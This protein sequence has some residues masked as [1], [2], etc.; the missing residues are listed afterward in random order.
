MQE[1]DDPTLRRFLRARDLEIEKASAM[2]LKHLKWRQ[3]FVPNGFI[4]L[5]EVPN[6]LSQNKMFLQGFDKK[7]RPVATLLGARHFQ[8]KLGGLDEFKRMLSKHF[9]HLNHHLRNLYLSSNLKVISCFLLDL[10]VL[11]SILLTKYAQGTN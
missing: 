9:E 3:T 4:S 10:Q 7:G 2:F 1:V 8:N 5:S 11:W 6:E